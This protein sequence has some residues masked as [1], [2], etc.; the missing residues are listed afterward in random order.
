MVVSINY[1]S[2]ENEIP[3][4]EPARFLKYMYGCQWFLCHCIFIIFACHDVLVE[5]VMVTL[6]MRVRKYT[7]FLYVLE[8]S[9]LELVSTLQFVDDCSQLSLHGGSQ[10]TI[11]FP[12]EVFFVIDPFLC[13]QSWLPPNRCFLCIEPYDMLAR[14]LSLFFS[15]VV[16][17]HLLDIGWSPSSGLFFLVML[18][19]Y[20]SSFSPFGSHCKEMT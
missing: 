11:Q 8:N 6:T 4:C 5:V 1:S 14:G 17:V 19:P 15:D 10:V 16:Q 18:L 12:S 3:S 7:F 2:P 9:H 13:K 20:N